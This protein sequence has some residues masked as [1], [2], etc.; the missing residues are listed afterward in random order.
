[1]EINWKKLE[2]GNFGVKLLGM[3]IS[4]YPMKKQIKAFNLCKEY[5]PS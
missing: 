1:M 2:R 3:L 5:S 4:N